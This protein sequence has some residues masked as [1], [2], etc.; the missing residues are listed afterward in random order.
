MSRLWRFW[1]QV[2]KEN[3]I[4]GTSPPGPP[5]NRPS[6]SPLY[7]GVCWVSPGVAW[8]SR[9]GSPRGGALGGIAWGGAGAPK[10]RQSRASPEE[11]CSLIVVIWASPSYTNF[12]NYRSTSIY[13]PTRDSETCKGGEMIHYKREFPP[14]ATKSIETIEQLANHTDSA[15]LSRLRRFNFQGSAY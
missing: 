6:F 14:N 11:R 2:I 13:V 8:E 5:H 10:F 12:R 9:R 4:F 7:W 15:R 1:G 3:L